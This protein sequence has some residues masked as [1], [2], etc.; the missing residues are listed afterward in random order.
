VAS[1][2][3]MDPSAP[4]WRPI[5]RA[6]TAAGVSLTDALPLPGGV[7]VRTALVGEAVGRQFGLAFVPMDADQ[8][9]VWFARCRAHATR[10]SGATDTGNEASTTDRAA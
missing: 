8:R 5:E 1:A 4:A 6:E 3:E 10:R 2:D 7:L 9:D